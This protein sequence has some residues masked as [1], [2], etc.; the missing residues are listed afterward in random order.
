MPLK[1][2]IF[3][4]GINKEGTQFSAGPTWFDCDKIRFRKGRPEVIGGWEKYIADSYLGVARSLFD[5]GTAGS[6]QY[7]GVGSNIKFYVETAGVI[8]DITPLRATNTG[9]STPFA[10]VANGDATIT[11][12]HTAHGAV[13]GDYT[14]ISGAVSLGGLI[15]AAVLNQ[16]YKIGTIVSANSY[17]IEAKDTS[18]AEVLANS[19]D[20]GNG[21]SATFEY[22]I[23]TGT[24]TY[25]A[26]FGWGAGPWGGS[27]WGGG[28]SIDF[29]S[30]LRLYSQTEFGDDL[31][32]NPRLGGVYYWD[33]DTA[34]RLAVAGDV[35]FAQVGNGDATITV[36][37]TAHGVY[38][39]DF[40]T[41]AGAV[42][43]GG[44]IT[45]AI[46][47]QKYRVATRVDADNY[48]IEAKDATTGAVVTTDGGGADSGNGGGSVE[49]SYATARGV[50][51]SNS[52]IFTTTSDAPTAALQVMVSQVDR[53]VIC[54]G[55]NT[56]GGTDID[57]LLVRWSDQENAV[58]WT[59]TATNTAG[60][61][62]LSTGTRIIGA[63]K[64]RQEI[65]IFT[66]TSIHAMRFSGNPFIFS[67]N[68][69]GENVT[70][71]SPKAAISVGDAVFFMDLEGFYIYQGSIKRLE[72]TVLNY[73]YSRMDTSQTYKVFSS[74]NPDDSEVTWY[75]P[76]TS[77]GEITDYVTYNYVENVWTV[78][79]FARAAWIQAQTKAHSIASSADAIN[80]E[81]NYL[82]SHEIG[83]N[84]D[85]AAI[86]PHI[87]SG[88]ISIGEG[89]RFVSLNK[90]IPDFRFTGT[91]ANA[92]VNVIIKKSDYPSDTPTT[93]STSA[94]TTAT[95]KLDIRVRG[96]EIILRIE[97]STGTSY[98]WT[99]GDFRFGLRTDGRR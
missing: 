90:I 18:G 91:T 30:Q 40:V 86:A 10:K 26:S 23:N 38:I 29:S 20:T 75:Y 66:D 33:E 74:N 70:I 44:N 5:W 89:D 63:I 61:Q 7:L 47:N 9:I 28:A 72:C 1:K 99:M 96:R 77:S 48:T 62:V 36:T 41:F 22:Q 39:G 54:F 58:D 65:L 51:L 8:A 6:L 45:A 88:E 97:D 43:L 79:T 76:A 84:A 78:G 24:N 81:T 34:A 94:V 19:S 50:A 95:R 92:S 35:T 46:L 53:H 64:T 14:T 16:E 98:G 85:G 55:V 42:S 17:T 32:F 59:P 68:S 15:T 83:F 67:F 52:T 2:I 49:G 27:P 57:P 69:V 93:V 82:Y 11:V 87:E 12:T 25:V 80:V 56:L 21:T 4:P 60:G 31:I 37:D 71:L 73:V 3:E 13:L